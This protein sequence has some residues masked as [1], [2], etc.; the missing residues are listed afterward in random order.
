[1]APQRRTMP[2]TWFVLTATPRKIQFKATAEAGKEIS[3][4]VA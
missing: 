1:M 3:A 4:S 2:T